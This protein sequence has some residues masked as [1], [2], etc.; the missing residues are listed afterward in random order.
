MLSIILLIVIILLSFRVAPRERAEHAAIH[1]AGQIGLLAA[2]ALFGV[3]YF[4]SYYYA[5]GEMLSALHPY[6]LQHYGYLTAAIIALGNLVFGGLY[7]YSLGIFNEGGGSYTASMRY[8]WPTL[9]LI[10]AVTLIQDYVFTIVVSGL[11]GVDQLLSV[12]NAYG[13]P[14]LVHFGLG[15]LLCA[16]TWYITIRGRGDSARVVFALLSIFVFLTVTMVVGLILAHVH[17]VAPVAAAEAPRQVSLAQALLHMLTATMKGMVALTGLEA[18]SNGIQFMIDEDVSLV[19]WGK[20][21]LPRLNP[22][23]HFYS[24]KSGIGRFVQT[25]FLFYGGVTTYLLTFFAIRF[26]VFDGTLGRTLVGNLSYIGFTQLPGGTVL[27]WA[28]QVLAVALLAAASMTAF[29]DVQATEWRDAAIGEIPDMIV[30]RDRHGTFTRSVTI[31]FGVAVLLMLAVRGQTTLAIPY[32]GIGVFMPIMVMGLAV[33][34]HI[35]RHATGTKRTWGVAGATVAAVMAGLVFV[36]QVVGKWQEGGWVV[37]ISFSMLALVAHLI[38]LSPVGHRTP[39]QIEHIVRDKARVQGGMATIVEWQSYKMQ[40]YRYRLL[41][42]ISGFLELFGVGQAYYRPALRPALAGAAPTGGLGPDV[43]A[44]PRLAVRWPGQ[45]AVRQRA[46]PGNGA[47]HGGNGH[48]QPAV[49]KI[50]PEI[51]VTPPNIMRHRLIVPINGIHQGTLTAMSYARSLSDDVTAIHVAEDPV[52]AERLRAEWELMGDGVRLVLLEAPHGMVLEPLIQYIQ[53]I[54]AVRQPREAIT[55]VVPQ[56]AQPRWWRT[57]WKSQ[58]A[59][60]LRISLPVETGVVIVD[61]PYE[62]A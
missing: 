22:L 55:I 31:T 37:L 32:Y 46:L 5:A 6:G 12:L 61:V 11:S 50:L 38:L 56:L 41:V 14:W 39:G 45:G 15:A 10:V 36:G 30:Y 53:R 42:G 3:D 49:P 25:S 43:K 7:M 54:V 18:V 1:G 24:G 28:Y 51:R 40:E 33:R 17:G 47:N 52:A 9:S 27:F 23:W 29:Q 58:M 13:A 60:L 59:T 19:K 44:L 35:Q 57:L 21:H 4:T 20:Q 62:L 48:V 2:V 34:K 26:N 16:G 8:L